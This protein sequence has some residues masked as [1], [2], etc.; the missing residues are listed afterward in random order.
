VAPDGQLLLESTE[1]LSLVQLERETLLGARRDYPGY[2]T[3]RPELYARGW[4]QLTRG[5]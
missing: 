2:L 4:A 5:D 1:P 3:R